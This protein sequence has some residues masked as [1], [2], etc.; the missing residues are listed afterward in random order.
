MLL[1]KGLSRCRWL[2]VPVL[3]TNSQ[4]L[5]E[6]Q[7]RFVWWALFANGTPWSVRHVCQVVFHDL[8]FCWLLWHCCCSC[9]DG[10]LVVFFILLKLF[11]IWWFLLKVCWSCPLLWM[12]WLWFSCPLIVDASWSTSIQWFDDCH[13][14]LKQIVNIWSIWCQ[15]L[16]IVSRG[17]SS[18]DVLLEFNS[19]MSCL[20]DLVVV[21]D[22]QSLECLLMA[23]VVA[24]LYVLLLVSLSMPL[25]S[26]R[27]LSFLSDALAW[28]VLALSL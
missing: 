6:M 16:T 18:K 13:S 11:L 21:C 27:Y 8:L 5:L 4:S 7:N 3:G 24:C 14:W 23:S 19:L 26:S 15:L 12:L 2:L 25:L 17:F 10:L 9:L 20:L 1:N 22:G 28:S